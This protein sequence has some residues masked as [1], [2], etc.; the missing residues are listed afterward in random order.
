MACL[1]NMPHLAMVI[2]I[3]KIQNS[4][5][6]VCCFFSYLGSLRTVT[7][8]ILN[9][10]VVS[11]Y[12]LQ[13]RSKRWVESSQVTP[14]MQW[15]WPLWK[16]QH[17]ELHSIIFFR[18]VDSS[19]NFDDFRFDLIIS[20]QLLTWKGLISYTK[21]KKYVI[22]KTKTFLKLI[23]MNCIKLQ[24]VY[25]NSPESPALTKHP[26]NVQKWCLK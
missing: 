10:I 23:K 17:F 2:V 12:N 18:D 22:S 6:K 14:T 11:R 24:Q 5:I 25:T 9:I 7:E 19:H 13:L 16:N 26:I 20:H 15:T 8:R 1:F 21:N 4:P 3:V